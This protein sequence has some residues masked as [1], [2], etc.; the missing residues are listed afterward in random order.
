MELECKSY[1]KTHSYINALESKASKL[2]FHWKLHQLDNEN[3]PRACFQTG[4][5]SLNHAK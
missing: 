4:C 5:Q 3:N 1:H 2:L